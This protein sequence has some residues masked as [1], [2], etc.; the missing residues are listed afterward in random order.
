M[1]TDI[2]AAIRVRDITGV[3]VGFIQA[4]DFTYKQPLAEQLADYLHARGW[5]RTKHGWWTHVDH[6]D[7]HHTALAVQVAKADQQKMLA[8]FEG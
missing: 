1:T 3:A 7:L 2:Q 8:Q 5:Q 4:H 6:P